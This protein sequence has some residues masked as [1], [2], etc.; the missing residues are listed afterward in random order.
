MKDMV[1]PAGKLFGP[2][3]GGPDQYLHLAAPILKNGLIRW[4]TPEE[5]GL[6]A[7]AAAP[8]GDPWG[9]PARPKVKVG[10]EHGD[11]M[12]RSY[13]RGSIVGEQCRAPVRR[14]T[15]TDGDDRQRASGNVYQVSGCYLLRVSQDCWRLSTKRRLVGLAHMAAYPQRLRSVPPKTQQG[16]F[17]FFSTIL[18][19][20]W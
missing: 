5:G 20:V 11:G 16:L 2:S 7:W 17:F 12:E 9:A 8:A 19:V 4:R 1:P 3:V 15:F 18:I 14:Q 10:R 6:T 13:Y